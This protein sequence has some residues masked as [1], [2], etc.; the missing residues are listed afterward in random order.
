[1]YKDFFGLR[2]APFSLTPDPRFLY[3][4][5]RHREALAALIY[6]IRDSKGFI[7]LTG[8]IGSGKTTL[9]RAFL[10]ELNA[11]TTHVA[12]I[13]NSFLSEIELL[14][15]VN[16]ELGIE[17]PEGQG[18]RELIDA[19]NRFL[20]QANAEGKTTILIVDEAQNLTPAVLEQ[21]RMLSNLETE[22]TKL[23]QI[24]L[25]GQPELLDILAKPELEQLN[26]RIIVRCHITPL[27]K[28][29]I[30]QY[31]RHRLHVAGAKLNISLTQP[32]LNRV[33]HYSRGI[34]R[35]INLLC[36][37]ALLAAYVAGVVQIDAKIVASAETE[38]RNLSG[39]RG[40][41]R[42]A[43]NPDSFMRFSLATSVILVSLAACVW[44]ISFAF[45]RNNT[46]GMANADSGWTDATP[47]LP[48]R[49]SSGSTT[50][51]LASS[52]RASVVATP[53]PA[54]PWRCDESG[55]IRVEDPEFAKVASLLTLAGLWKF[56]FEVQFFNSQDKKTILGLNMMRV[57]SRAP[58]SFRSFS[59]GRD[60]KGAMT[61]NLPLALDIEQPSTATLAHADSATSLS[62]SVV[63]VRFADGKCQVADP[64]FGPIAIDLPTLEKRV[65]QATVLYR[66]PDNLAALAPGEESDAVEELRVFL[67]ELGLWGQAPATRSVNE[68][69]TR[70]IKRYQE[71]RGQKPT[72]EIDGVTAALIA[73]E[74][75]SYWPRLSGESAGRGPKKKA[76]KGR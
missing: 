72:G 64:V 57:L 59:A 21:I 66:D 9:C 48:G 18:K 2:E 29:E 58:M 49:R 8:E 52:R 28:R 14:Q 11:E 40:A 26:Q 75:Q 44:A 4:S 19:L 74:R 56:P 67:T 61:L 63:L 54:G 25:I 37:R 51:T 3:M 73:L 6:G 13:L 41:R 70:A 46:Q 22:R 12:L 71:R 50:G 43:P 5:Q 20:L 33:Y 23:I 1:M 16:Q 62:S 36:D 68:D 39:G 65:A 34:P 60:L 10:K 24:V 69:M 15:S 31:I 27:N 38:I 47:A 42:L 17:T 30:Y 76:D 7:L 45:W 55:G 53:T 32:A 35:K